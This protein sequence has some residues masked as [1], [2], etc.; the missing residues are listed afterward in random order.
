MASTAHHA[1]W[2]IVALMGPATEA[3]TL[4]PYE[5][6]AFCQVS[7]EAVPPGTAGRCFCSVGGVEQ[8]FTPPPVR[9]VH[10]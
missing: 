3:S 9:P 10:A 8:P 4:G 2:I 6:I 1:P 5:L 7:E